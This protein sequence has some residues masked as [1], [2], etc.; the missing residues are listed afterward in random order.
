VVCKNAEKRFKS[1]LILF[2]TDSA[3]AAI[4]GSISG[5]NLP[6][7]VIT[8]NVSCRLVMQREGVIKAF[9]IK[10]CLPD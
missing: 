2:R 1:A 9:H 6:K 3:V 5:T 8:G 10:E 4:I 7:I